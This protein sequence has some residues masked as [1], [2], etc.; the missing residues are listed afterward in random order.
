MP[1]DITWA[2]RRHWAKE[3]TKWL[4]ITADLIGAALTNGGVIWWLSKLPG[5]AGLKE[6]LA[7]VVI[8]TVAAGILA[9]VIVY[10][11]NL[12][13][14]GEAIRTG[15]LEETERLLKPAV[16]DRDRLIAEKAAVPR[17]KPDISFTESANAIRMNVRNSGSPAV[18]HANSVVL[19]ANAG[20]GEVG[21]AQP[22]RWE[23]AA[24][25][26]SKIVTG[27]EDSCTV[28]VVTR[29]NHPVVQVQVQAICNSGLGTLGPTQAYWSVN[30]LPQA[31]GIEPTRPC[32]LCELTITAEPEML[33]GP[34]C[35]RF[36]LGPGDFYEEGSDGYMFDSEG[37]LREDMG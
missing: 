16:R 5:R 35:K 34:I 1:E 4:P 15:Q 30:W 8:A 11:L 27:G 10:C 9:P 28:A 31:V 32:A 19:W 6:Y 21:H 26:Q 24:S 3:H 17:P 7:G 20:R 22:L 33:E 29:E 37:R 13:R 14:A 2:D 18:F 23:R 25:T 36:Q 12:V